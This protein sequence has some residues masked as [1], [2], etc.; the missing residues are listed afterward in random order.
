MR[1]D[2]ARILVIGAGVNGCACAT[3]LYKAGIDV[4]VLARGKRYD[5]IKTEGIIIE[6][7]FNK[8][9]NITK[10]PVINELQPED[11][12]DYILVI[13]RKNQI[14]DLL[15]V[16]ANNIS[17][18]IVFMGNTLSSPDDYI[19]AIGKDRVLMGSVFAGG[20]R[21]NNIIKAFI[22]KSIAGAVG[23]VDGTITPRLIRLKNILR[24]GGF[25]STTSTNI[26]DALI[27][28]A[29][30]L[31]VLALSVMKYKLNL[32][33]LTKSTEDLFLIVDAT[34]E[35][36]SV[37]KA[38]GYKIIPK[39]TNM[40]YIIPRFIQVALLSILLKTKFFEVGGVYHI[41]QAPDEM[42][43]LAGELKDLVE[44]SG[45]PVPAIR[46]VLKMN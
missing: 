19:K 34:R 8:K 11:I 27:T 21:E 41:S 35:S 1:T 5:D 17:P 28:H 18:N 30:G 6:N 24:Q 37:I 9:R 12:Y 13:I 36:Y 26:V 40:I 32:R 38:L 16:L 20:R 29:A 46:K 43:F 45:L 39:S 23:E 2:N 44:K 33:E 25:K 4:T 3:E 42:N 14:S 7:P 10:V 31:P 15:P 22:V